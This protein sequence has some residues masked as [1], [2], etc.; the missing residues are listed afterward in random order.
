MH[1]EAGELRDVA[2]EKLRLN[3]LRDGDL[4][5]QALFCFLVEDQFLDMF[6]FLLTVASL[7]GRHTNL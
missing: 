7:F 4:I 6:F 2:R 1:F 5:F 3:L